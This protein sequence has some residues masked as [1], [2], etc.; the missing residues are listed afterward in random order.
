MKRKKYEKMN[1]I[2]SIY[3]TSTHFLNIIKS[4]VFQ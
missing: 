3:L 1:K 4:S 2:G